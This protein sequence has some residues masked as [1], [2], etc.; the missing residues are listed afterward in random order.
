MLG[1]RRRLAILAEGSFTPLEG[2]TAVGVLRYCP[3]EVAAVIDSTRAGRTAEACVGLGGAVPVVGDLAGAAAHGAD[4]LLI[5]IAPQ[6]GELPAA[7]RVMVRAAIE[8]GWDVLSG[9]H[10]F[11][12][13]DPELAALAGAR[14]VDLLDVRRPP[15]RRP[16]A[17]ARAAGVEA[18]VVLT[19]GSDCNVGKMTAALELRRE[20]QERGVRAAFVATG[21]TGI[22]IAGSGLPM[23]AVVS[24][25]LSGAA[26]M[27][28]PDAHPA[29]WDVIE[30]QGSLSHPAYAGVSLGILHGSQPDIF[31]LCHEPSRSHLLGY[32]GFPTP[33]LADAIALNLKCGALTN[34]A[35]RCGG[36]SFNT[37][38]LSAAEA[39]AV[40]REASQALGL[41]VADPIRGGPA[42]ERLVEACLG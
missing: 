3:D 22:M 41:P 11:L 32:P 30:G 9:L 19:V 23:D 28:S 2:K 33:P 34:P 4:S 40:M 12:A 29:H 36:I 35:I 15:A 1:K 17:A 14:G 39:D 24:D 21:Q 13:D 16:V 18:L 38:A 27:L 10:S 5:G 6:G 42:F 20:L 37:S 8:R 31:V 25:F 26:E 7:W